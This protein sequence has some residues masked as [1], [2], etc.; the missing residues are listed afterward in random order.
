MRIFAPICAAVLRRADGESES[1]GYFELIR[2]V[3]C[4]ID[5]ALPKQCG[6]VAEL[7]E[8]AILSIGCRPIF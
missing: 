7:L 2:A 6:R 4:I 1:L 8:T 3:L 5:G